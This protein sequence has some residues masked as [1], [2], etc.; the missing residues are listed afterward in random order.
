MNGRSRAWSRQAVA[1]VSIQVARS[2]YLE[3]FLIAGYPLTVAQVRHWLPE[4][5]DAAWP[6]DE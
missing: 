3:P 1:H 5:E 2:G 6:A 4:Y